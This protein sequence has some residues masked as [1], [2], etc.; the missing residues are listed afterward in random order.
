MNIDKIKVIFN[1]YKNDIKNIRKQYS[2]LEIPEDDFIKLVL[3]EI[4]KSINHSD[5]SNYQHYLM[6]RIG[7]SLSI[8]VINY[9]SND[10]TSYIIVNNYI[11]K[12]FDITTNES[13]IIKKFNIIG[14]FFEK[15]SYIPSDILIKKI[16]LNNTIING[17]L[18]NMY[19][20]YYRN[21]NNGQISKLFNNQYLIN[22]I[23]VY[24]EINN[25]EFKDDFILNND[26]SFVDCS[27]S[28]KMYLNN[29][30]NHKPLTLQEEQ[31]LFQKIRKGDAEARRI[32]IE[33]NL[34][35]VVSIATRYNN[36]YM[37]LMDLIEEGNIGLLIA[38]NKFDETKGFKF[39]TYAV[40]WIKQAITRAIAIKGRMIRMPVHIT[41]KIGAYNSA[42]DKLRLLLKREP[43]DEEI[44]EYM[45]VTVLT[46]S[47]IK[48]YKESI[49][50]LDIYVN[51]EE[52][53]ELGDFIVDNDTPSPLDVVL[54]SSLKEEIS[55]L[56]DS[57]ILNERET[58]ILK[59]RFGFL[60]DQ[61][62]Y[63]LE[64]ISK[65]F[66]VTRERIR[67]VQNIAL[68]KIRR[69]EKYKDL[70][71]YLDEPDFLYKRR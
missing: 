6:K 30:P 37:S 48:K 39:A 17:Y 53:A 35:L 50:S 64:E 26:D 4:N 3:K 15:Y 31:I 38:V 14:K 59:M 7:I 18:S 22:F 67:Q 65:K 23:R 19:Q 49:L 9:L 43:L 24:C 16:I 36:P 21:I 58:T 41:E 60:E 68:N 5:E 20:K 1:K 70:I 11:N 33:N 8:V 12:N 56:L 45:H 69:S 44:A 61:R 63:S 40:F 13:E 27:D 42:C 52:D 10:E 46:I 47:K 29:I 54:E 62:C 55:N 2:F 28:L 51:D 32:V 66:N 25:F 71:M 57:K 34:K